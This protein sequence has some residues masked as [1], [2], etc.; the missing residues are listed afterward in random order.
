MHIYRQLSDINLSADQSTV[1]TIGS[2]DGVHRGHRQIISNLKR[3]AIEHQALTALIAF[4][5][6][7]AAIFS[8]NPPGDYLTTIQEK[9]ALFETFQLDLVAIIPFSFEFAQTSA[10]NFI[11]QIVTAFAPVELWVGSDFQFG[12]DRQGNV[13]LLQESGRQMGFTVSNVDLQFL[14]GERVSST[15]I[16]QAVS[17]GDV[18]LAAHLLGD[19]AFFMG[20]VILG[21]QR[22]RTLGF[23]T[24]NIAIDRDKLLPKNGVYAVWF[25]V[26]DEI[27]PAVANVGIRPT[28]DGQTKTVEVHVFDFAG[29]IYN[30]A[31]R[32]DWVAY[33]R[34][35]RAFNGVEAL[36]KQIQAD[37]ETARIILAKEPLP[38]RSNI[39]D[40]FA[41]ETTTSD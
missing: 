4:H 22:G 8:S 21:A 6:R 2:Y 10:H 17:D 30:Q 16:R 14:A 18:R 25:Q 20:E 5:P 29:D 23:P 35:E 19:Y 39:I 12:R 36:V 24:A 3:A 32:V 34:E 37:S 26:D 31:V 7:P 15:R 28:F 27:L 33:I 41:P 38:A 13:T 9:I 40:Q 1:L 11:E